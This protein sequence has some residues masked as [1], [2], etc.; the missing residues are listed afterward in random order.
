MSEENLE[1]EYKVYLGQALA[2]LN[3]KVDNVDT[4]QVFESLTGSSVGAEDARL[5]LDD[6][7]ERFFEKVIDRF[8]QLAKDAGLDPSDF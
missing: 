2:L 8:P 5:E 3:T 1:Y 6:A 7:I 4:R